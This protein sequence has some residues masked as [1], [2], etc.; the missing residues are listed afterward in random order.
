MLRQALAYAINASAGHSEDFQHNLSSSQRKL[1]IATPQL[2]FD[3]TWLKNEHSF[4]SDKTRETNK[5]L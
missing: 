5:S 2:K 1:L 3:S 4:H